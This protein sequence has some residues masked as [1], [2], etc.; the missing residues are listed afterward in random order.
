MKYYIQK[1]NIYNIDGEALGEGYDL[2][3]TKTLDEFQAGKVIELNNE[4]TEFMLLY[5]SASTIE[6]FNCKLNEQS[7]PTLEQIKA[8]KIAK[9]VLFDSSPTV[10]SFIIYD[11]KMWLERSTRVSLMQTATILEQAGQTETTLWT[12]GNNPQSIPVTISNLKQ[13]L[14]ELE[15]YA[16]ACYDTTAQHKQN[17]NQ[18]NS[19]QEIENYDFKRNYPSYINLYI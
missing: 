3:S 10:N 7:E 4:Q 8:E 6:I 11:K 12:E 13:F 19:I 14:G 16:K 5:P 18:L 2:S 9:L 15:I 1:S 17:I